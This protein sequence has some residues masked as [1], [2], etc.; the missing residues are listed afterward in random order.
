MS[1]MTAIVID[2]VSSLTGCRRGSPPRKDVIWPYV[3]I[4]SCI[5]EGEVCLICSLLYFVSSY[6]QL[7]IT[8]LMLC[9]SSL[10]Q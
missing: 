5:I 3:I 7:E 4:S 8:C 10:S 2:L 9:G 1:S 6:V